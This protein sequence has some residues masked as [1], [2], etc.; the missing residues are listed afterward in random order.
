MLQVCVKEWECMLY[1]SFTRF[2]MR[3]Y[4]LVRAHVR[5]SFCVQYCC[6]CVFV[7]DIVVLWD[8][9]SNCECG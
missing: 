2:R 9:L 8:C 6:V 7:F 1:I 5:V 3:L 4:A